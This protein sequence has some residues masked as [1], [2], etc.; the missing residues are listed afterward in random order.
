[1]KDKII[2]LEKQVK[3]YRRLFVAALV[4]WV[5]FYLSLS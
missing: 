3:K 4:L 5:L 2:K 1:M